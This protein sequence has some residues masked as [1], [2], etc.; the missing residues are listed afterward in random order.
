MPDVTLS[1][2]PAD[3]ATL[4]VGDPWPRAYVRVYADGAWQTYTIDEGDPPYSA[5]WVDPGV[6]DEGEEEVEGSSGAAGPPGLDGPPGPPG[7]QGEPG[8]GITHRGDWAAETTYSYLDVVMHDGVSW[9][10]KT[11]LNLDHEPGEP[12][13]DVNWGV[14]SEQGPPGPEGPDGPPGP[15]GPQGP[16]GSPLP[17]RDETIITT[18]SLAPNA[19]AVGTVAL[20]TGYRIIHLA[21]DRPSWVCLYTTTAKRDA[22]AGRAIT[23]DPSGDHG[24]VVEVVTGIELGFDLSP[25][26]QGYSMEDPP[27]ATIPYRI[28]NLGTDG[29]V[30]VTLTWQPQED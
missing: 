10:S 22:D 4:N 13:S 1:G 7:P 19:A 11:D 12:T 29:S 26:P 21:T 8:P 3:G 16:V 15:E 23:E 20:A 14:L 25:V 5:T 17:L 28:T 6:P 9:M 18:A 2:G 30:A 27:V 24:L